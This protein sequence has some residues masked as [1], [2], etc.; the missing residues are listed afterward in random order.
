VFKQQG[1]KRGVE[2]NVLLIYNLG[3]IRMCV[4]TIQLPKFRLRGKGTIYTLDGMF[5][6]ITFLL[7]QE[8]NYEILHLILHY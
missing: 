3:I 6:C 8:Q 2:V 7:T 4:V 1:I 5:D